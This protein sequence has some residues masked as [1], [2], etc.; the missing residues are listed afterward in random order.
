M[1]TTGHA[2]IDQQHELLDHMVEQ[3][4]DF[5]SEA[6]KVAEPACSH[7]P[8]L[9]SRHCSNT[10]AAITSELMAFLQ[11]HAVYEE[12]MMD[13]LPATPSCLSELAQKIRFPPV[14]V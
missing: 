4:A 1:T 10:L 13:L 7:C 6:E 8:A 14:V 5:C 2:E 12:K 11:G 3:L 9:K